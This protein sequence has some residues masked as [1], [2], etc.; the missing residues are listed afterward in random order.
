[1][2]TGRDQVAERC[3]GFDGGDI[4]EQGTGAWQRESVQHAGLWRE[5]RASVKVLRGEQIVHACGTNSTA[6]AGCR[7]GSSQWSSSRNANSAIR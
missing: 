1:M 3:A 4:G 6:A 7:N 2:T 5:L